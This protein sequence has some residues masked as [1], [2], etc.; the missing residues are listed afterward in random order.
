MFWIAPL[1]SLATEANASNSVL[2]FGFAYFLLVAWV[3]AVLAFRRAADANISEA[4]ATAAMAP[5]VQIPVILGLA[6]VPPRERDAPLP[7]AK[8]GDRHYSA[9]VLGVIAGIGVTL[10]AVAISTLGFGVYGYGLF[11]VS[12]FFIGATTAYFAN[13]KSDVGSG[14]TA[15]LVLG[16]TALGGIGLVV[17]ALE[18]LVCILLASPLVAGV[19]VVGGALGRAVA[20]AGNRPARQVAPA[21]AVL[22]LVL[23]LE[24]LFVPAAS[25]DTIQS[26]TINAPA[27]T[28]WQS[29]LHMD[30]IDGPLALPFR[31]GVAYP[32]RGDVLGEGV[33]AIRHGEF[34]TGTAI[35]R[36]TEWV[37]NRRLAFV[38]E[39][40]IPAMREMSPY[41]HVHAPHV[42]GYFTTRATSFELAPRADGATEVTLRSSHE[43]RLDPLLYWMPL[44]RWMVAQNNA[45][46]LA[47]IRHQAERSAHATL[48]PARSVDNV[49]R[50]PYR[51]VPS[52]SGR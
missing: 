38:V 40:D 39:N 16:A 33:G 47:H 52:M 19:A 43:I 25:F 6:V 1:R 22:P 18:G 5:V 26:I 34:S 37:P 20:V 28:V 27:E 14:Q 49:P 46:V 3:L 21:F 36:V 44:A 13:R 41:E 10:A 23:V 32:V 51:E 9:V 2:I 4:I 7:V 12:P 30:R 17:A 42:I 35:E 15:R 31:F 50:A 8:L 24:H 48:T 29:V 45:R 11:V